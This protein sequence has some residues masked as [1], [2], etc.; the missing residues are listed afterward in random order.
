MTLQ[1]AHPTFQGEGHLILLKN[2]FSPTQF[3]CSRTLSLYP[4]SN[5]IF[6]RGK[7]ERACNVSTFFV[8][9]ENLSYF[10]IF[11]IL[12]TNL[13]PPI[14][15][16]PHLS[17]SPISISSHPCV[18]VETSK[19]KSLLVSRHYPAQPFHPDL[20]LAFA[21]GQIFLESFIASSSI[22]LLTG[23]KYWFD[24]SLVC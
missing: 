17:E 13:S 21:L 20:V 23:D 7:L 9:M 4:T 14:L 12:L 15:I 10:I 2:L 16:L 6:T 3:S 18:L 1:R 24:V 8:V 19:P 11:S 5:C 22:K